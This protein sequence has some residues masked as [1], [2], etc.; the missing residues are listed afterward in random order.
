MSSGHPS[1]QDLLCNALG[2]RRAFHL[3]AC[4]AA[5]WCTEVEP[6]QSSLGHHAVIGEPLRTACLYVQAAHVDY[7]QAL[8]PPAAKASS[9]CQTNP[10]S[11]RR[12]TAESAPLNPAPLY[13]PDT[14]GTAG[15]PS[16]RKETQKRGEIEGRRRLFRDVRQLDAG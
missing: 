12:H 2:D 13:R 15:L 1:F 8:G 4:L 3:S 6:L 9:G 11:E 7:L 16:F 10:S 5:R 14:S